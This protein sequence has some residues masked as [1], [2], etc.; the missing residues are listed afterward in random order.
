MWLKI[1]CRSAFFSKVV[2]TS[3]E[4][5]L[6]PVQCRQNWVNKARTAAV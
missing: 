1:A 2:V 6:A 5:T 3:R 4:S